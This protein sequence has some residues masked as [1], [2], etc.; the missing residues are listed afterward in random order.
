MVSY[1]QVPSQPIP[2]IKYL[3]VHQGFAFAHCNYATGARSTMY[4]HRGKHHQ[5]AGGYHTA[6]GF[7]TSTVQ[8]FSNFVCRYFPVEVSTEGERESTFDPAQQELEMLEAIIQESRG[9][10]ASQLNAMDAE[11]LTPW[12]RRTGWVEHLGDYPLIALAKSAQQKPIMSSRESGEDIVEQLCMIGLAFDRVWI[13][14]EAATRRQT[15]NSTMTLLKANKLGSYTHQ[16]IVPF[17]VTQEPSTLKRYKDHWKSYILFLCRLGL[18]Q[19][20]P[21]MARDLI[22]TPHLVNIQS[23]M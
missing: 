15:L 1:L 5:L 8:T 9:D 17:Q 16:N 6:Q 19:K 18:E 2:A 23:C 21:N 3:K 20:R 22:T 11:K 7:K 13:K 4:R 14:A 10:P 12:L